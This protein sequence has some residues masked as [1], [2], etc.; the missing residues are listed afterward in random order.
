MEVLKIG[1][2]KISKYDNIILEFEVLEDIPVDNIDEKIVDINYVMFCAKK[3]KITKIFDYY[4]KISYES[5][6]NKGQL[7]II[8]DVIDI[9]NYKF[10]YNF[11]IA[12]KCILPKG[13]KYHLSIDG[14]FWFNFPDCPAYIKRVCLTG[15]MLHYFIR[16]G[17]LEEEIDYIRGERNG[18]VRRYHYG[19]G[20]HIESEYKN[21]KSID[22]FKN[23]DFD[24][25][26]Y[27]SDEIYKN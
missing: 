15:K 23:Y 20:I 14:A 27:W 26:V 24:G 17:Q 11:D 2:K 5:I 9:N 3:I 21:N 19:G 6:N 25:N 10:N 22:K 7:Y 16:N 18:F 1:Y 8:D 12:D 13:I 4:T